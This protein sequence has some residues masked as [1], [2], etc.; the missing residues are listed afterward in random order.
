MLFAAAVLVVLY[1]HREHQEGLNTG[2]LGENGANF[3][4]TSVVQCRLRNTYQRL[5]GCLPVTKYKALSNANQA[6]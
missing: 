6:E 1:V 3:L 4:L 5:G 2:S